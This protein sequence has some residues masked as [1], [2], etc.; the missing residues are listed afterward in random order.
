MPWTSKV[1]LGAAVKMPTL[2]LVAS[3]ERVLVSKERPLTPPE[4]VKLVSLAN[5]QAS[6]LEVSVSPE[7]SPR[8]VLPVMEALPLMV[9]D[10]PTIAWAL[11]PLEI[12]SEPAKEEE[13]VPEKVLVPYVKK[14]PDTLATPPNEA[15][16]LTSKSELINKSFDA[17]M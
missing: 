8:V 12:R 7:A 9:K 6:A 4:R 15:V 1:V 17:E 3:M 16:P 2:L 11:R 5:V 10:V 13:P 14:L